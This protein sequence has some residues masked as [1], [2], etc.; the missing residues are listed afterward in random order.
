[1]LYPTLPRAPRHPRPTAPAFLTTLVMLAIALVACG[2]T[3]DSQTAAHTDMDVQRIFREELQP[4][5]PIFIITCDRLTVLKQT[6]AALA[7]ASNGA[8][9]VIIHDN[10]STFPPMVA[11]L[12]ELE[13][14]GTKVAWRTEPADRVEMLDGVSETIEAWYRDHD[15]PFYAVTDP[16]VALEDNTGVALTLYAELLR[17]HPKATVVGPMLR[18]DDIPDF[19]PFKQNAIDTWHALYDGVTPLEEKF[20]G[21]TVRLLAGPIDTTFGMYRGNFTFHRLNRG[22]S[23]MPPYGAWHLDW[24]L[25]PRALTDDQTYYMRHASDVSHVGGPWMREHVD[26]EAALAG[27]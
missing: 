21:R 10:H 1:M 24:Y 3:D 9:E 19:N 20:K 27:G 23:V 13:A 14:Q 5:I 25:D 18:V 16:D 6:I 22:Y 15:A 8:Y 26:R 11:Y 12:K 7:G 4:L 2:G 17:R